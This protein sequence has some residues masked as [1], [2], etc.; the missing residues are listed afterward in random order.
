MKD[1]KTSGKVKSALLSTWRHYIYLNRRI[2]VSN[3][4]RMKFH[5]QV[6]DIATQNKIIQIHTKGYK[7][8]KPVMASYKSGSGEERKKSENK[9]PTHTR[10]L[11]NYPRS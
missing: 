1:V 8:V 11:S 6:T 3:G 5:I 10:S 4:H 2:Y 9:T 7:T